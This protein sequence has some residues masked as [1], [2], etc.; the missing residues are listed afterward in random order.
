MI[1]VKERMAAYQA[2][3]RE[4]MDYANDRVAVY[5]EFHPWAE[6]WELT[7]VWNQEIA[8]YRSRLRGQMAA[9]FFIRDSHLFGDAFDDIP[10]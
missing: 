1:N 10:F 9:E 4:A 2:R 3:L 7:T 6:E 8:R 5:E